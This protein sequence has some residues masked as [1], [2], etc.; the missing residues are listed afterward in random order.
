M[1]KEKVC[2][3]KPKKTSWNSSK[4]SSNQKAIVFRLMSL[5]DQKSCLVSSVPVGINCLLSLGGVSLPGG[6]EACKAALLRR[7]CHLWPRRRFVAHSCIPLSHHGPRSRA[8]WA[9]P[10]CVQRPLTAF[11][12]EMIVS[13]IDCCAHV[14]FSLI[15]KS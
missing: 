13:V 11:V 12:G 4:M 8:V 2:L 9:T 3:S 5:P 15:M 14:V 7:Y 10:A 1:K 6:P